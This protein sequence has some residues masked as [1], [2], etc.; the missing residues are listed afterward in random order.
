MVHWQVKR[1]NQFRVGKPRVAI[2]RNRIAIRTHAAAPGLDVASKKVLYARMEEAT[3]L[4]KRGDST[5][6]L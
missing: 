5:G 6:E 1:R 3:E 2:Y 4:R